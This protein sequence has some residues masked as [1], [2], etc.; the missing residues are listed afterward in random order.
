MPNAA[1]T[2]GTCTT[3]DHPAA[4][5]TITAS[6]TTIAISLRMK[7][8]LPVPIPPKGDVTLRSR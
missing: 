1:L 8:G 3:P 5:V 6:T 2:M 7:P 4:P